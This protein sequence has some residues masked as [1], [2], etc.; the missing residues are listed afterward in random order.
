MIR[1]IPFINEN[2][3]NSL[4]YV[5][6]IS[7]ELVCLIDP[8][9][10]MNLF[11]YLKTKKIIPNLIFL[12]HEHYDHISGTNFLK[13]KYP[14]IKIICSNYCSKS[15]LD[16]KKNLSVYYSDP[17]VSAPA[18]LQILTKTRIIIEKGIKIDLYPFGGHSRG[19]L[20]IKIKDLVFVGDQFIRNEKTVTKLPGGSKQKLKE[21][22]NFM[23]GL[24]NIT[25]IYPGHGKPFTISDLNLW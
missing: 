3:Y 24:K 7:N 4:T 13:E 23:K 2:F 1:V 18:D 10:N 6:I 17:F 21:S 12:T 19:G 16:P 22:F 25:L 8:C 11:T 20:I 14:E 15:I 9:F 5:V